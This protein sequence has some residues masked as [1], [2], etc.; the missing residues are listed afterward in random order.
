MPSFFPTNIPILL[1]PFS[2]WDCEWIQRATKTNQTVISL[3]PSGSSGLR[4]SRFVTPRF[5]SFS[6]SVLGLSK[7]DLN[8]RLNG[9]F[10]A[11]LFVN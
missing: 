11:I 6:L 10:L 5:D 3:R 7:W 8:L 9:T 2:L 4:E 1:T